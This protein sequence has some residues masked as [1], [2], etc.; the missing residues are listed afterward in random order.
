MQYKPVVSG[1]CPR[2]ECLGD[3]S[4]LQ[5]RSLLHSVLGTGTEPLPI[6]PS[7]A[8]RIVSLS[9]LWTSLAAAP[10]V[11]TGYAHG[12]ECNL[13]LFGTGFCFSL[14]KGEFGVTQ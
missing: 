7:H 5:P 4:T 6:H 9:P 13:K 8:L 10:Y 14:K 12:S 2:T 1:F 11:G 3:P